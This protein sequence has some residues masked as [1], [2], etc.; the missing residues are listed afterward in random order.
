[1][2]QSSQQVPR[3]QDPRFRGY[4]RL[5]GGTGHASIGRTF[6]AAYRDMNFFHN[7]S[8]W[9]EDRR[10]YKADPNWTEERRQLHLQMGGLHGMVEKYPRLASAKSLSEYRMV[11]QRASQDLA[12]RAILHRLGFF[13]SLMYYLPVGMTSPENW[14]PLSRAFRFGMVGKRAG[15]FKVVASKAHNLA[16]EAERRALAA[17]HRTNP[18]LVHAAHLADDMT[19]GEAQ[20]LLARAALAQTTVAQAGAATGLEG[21]IAASVSEMLLQKVQ[22][23]RTQEET[24]MS[25][26][27]GGVFGA[28]LGS[29]FYVIGKSYRKV[30]TDLLGAETHSDRARIASHEAQGATTAALDD[31]SLGG[32]KHKETGD[33]LP[34]GEDPPPGT[35]ADFI[36]VEATPEDVPGFVAARVEE[37][38]VARAEAREA[39]A[40]EDGEAREQGQLEFEQ[41]TIETEATVQDL[42]LATEAEL[43]AAHRFAER[44]GALSED[45]NSVHSKI[46]R[47]VGIGDKNTFWG[48]LIGRWLLWSPNTRMGLEETDYGRQLYQLFSGGAL[49]MQRGSRAG[50]ATRPSIDITATFMELMLLRDIGT[51]AKMA[52]EIEASS[53]VSEIDLRSLAH[54]YALRALDDTGAWKGLDL[55]AEYPVAGLLGEGEGHV[56]GIIRNIEDPTMKQ[57]AIDGVERVI[58]E[59]YHPFIEKS[60]RLLQAMGLLDYDTARNPAMAAMYV[61]RMYDSTAIRRN[62]DA[63][64]AAVKEGLQEFREADDPTLRRRIEHQEAVVARE[65]NAADVE[66]LAE[67]KGDLEALRGDIDDAR[68]HAVV[69]NIINDPINSDLSGSRMHAQNALHKRVL[70]LKDEFVEPFLVKD[71]GLVMQTITKRHI[72]KV[73]IYRYLASPQQ[74]ELMVRTLEMRERVELGIA[75]L[76]DASDKIRDDL[77]E[78]EIKQF[79]GMVNDLLQEINLLRMHNGLRLLSVF[80]NDVAGLPVEGNGQVFDLVGH[81]ERIAELLQEGRDTSDTRHGVALRLKGL[82]EELITLSREAENAA[83]PVEMSAGPMDLAELEQHKAGLRRRMLA[84]LVERHETDPEVQGGLGDVAAGTAELHREGTDGARAAKDEAFLSDLEG[85]VRDRVQAG[86]DEIAG[87]PRVR[88][89][90]NRGGGVSRQ[91]ANM[92]VGRWLVYLAENIHDKEGL[93]SEGWATREMVDFVEGRFLRM[94]ED[95]RKNVPG[96]KGRM[97]IAV[98]PDDVKILIEAFRGADFSTAVHEVGH[99]LRMRTL[100]RAKIR[101]D[102]AGGITED[103]LEGLELWANDGRALSDLVDGERVWTTAMEEKFAKAFEQYIAEG[104]FAEGV[105]RAVKRVFE[106]LKRA[107]RAVYGVIS[108]RGGHWEEPL[109]PAVKKV[110]DK[111]LLSDDD[112]AAYAIREINHKLTATQKRQIKDSFG[113]SDEGADAIYAIYDALNLDKRELVFRAPGE[114][115]PEGFRESGG[116]QQGRQTFEGFLADN[117]VGMDDW[118]REATNHPEWKARYGKEIIEGRIRT[119]GF[120]VESSAGVLFRDGLAETAR[121]HRFGKAVEVKDEAFYLDPAVRVYLARDATAGLVITPE[122]DLISVHKLP[123]SAADIDEI[124]AQASPFAETLDAFDI[125]GHLPTLYARHGWRPVSRAEFNPE[126]RPEGWDMRPIDEGGLGKPDIVLMVY[127]P[128]DVLRLPNAASFNAVRGEVPFFPMAKYDDAVALHKEAQGVLRRDAPGRSAEELE[129]K[130]KQFFQQSGRESFVPDMETNAAYL[131]DELADG[132]T[133]LLDAGYDETRFNYLNDDGVEVTLKNDGEMIY[134]NGEQFTGDI[135]I[136]LILST[137]ARGQGAASKELDRILA[138]ADARDMSVSLVV[139]AQNVRRQGQA[140]GLNDAQLKAWYQRKGFVFPHDDPE[141]TGAGYRPRKADADSVIE[142]TRQA[143]EVELPAAMKQ[144]ADD[145]FKR[146][147]SEP[148]EMFG[149]FERGELEP[150]FHAAEPDLY[151]FEGYSPNAKEKL[152]Y[153]GRGRMTRAEWD[154]LVKDSVQSGRP[155]RVDNAVVD[156]DYDTG[157]YTASLTDPPTELRQTSEPLIAFRAS[158]G[159][160]ASARQVHSPDVIEKIWGDP[161]PGV[162]GRDT[163]EDTPI[164]GRWVRVD[165]DG[166]V[167]PNLEGTPENF[168][169]PL[170]LAELQ[171]RGY[172]G[173][174]RHYSTEW[175]ENV[176]ERH[177]AG[178]YDVPYDLL[179]L[180]ERVRE[181]VADERYEA[182]QG[183]P[184]SSDLARVGMDLEATKIFGPAERV[185]LYLDSINHGRV[186]QHFGMLDQAPRI[187]ADAIK[188]AT[189]KAEAILLSRIEAVVARQKETLPGPDADAVAKTIAR[190]IES[191][192]ISRQVDMSGGILSHRKRSARP[193]ITK[194]NQ[195]RPDFDESPVNEIATKSQKFIYPD[196]YADERPGGIFGDE[197]IDRTVERIIGTITKSNKEGSEAW[198]GAAMPLIARVGPLYKF[199][200]ETA[201]APDG[202]ESLLHAM[203][204]EAVAEY[205]KLPKRSGPL[206]LALTAEFSGSD[207]H[208][209]STELKKL[210]AMKQDEVKEKGGVFKSEAAEIA[211]RQKRLDAAES[212]G[213]T[214][215]WYNLTVIQAMQGAGGID[216]A[217][218]L[219]RAIMDLVVESHA[220]GAGLEAR[221]KSFE[222]NIRLSK[223][224]QARRLEYRKKHPSGGGFDSK[225]WREW[226]AAFNKEKW[227]PEFGE[228]SRAEAHGFGHVATDPHKSKPN[229]PDLHSFPFEG[230]MVDLETI[231]TMLPRLVEEYARY[232][233]EMHAMLRVMYPTGLVPV[234]RKRNYLG[235]IRAAEE[236][237]RV[238]SHPDLRPSTLQTMGDRYSLSTSLANPE[239]WA[240]IHRDDPSTVAGK[241]VDADK[242]AESDQYRA[243]DWV[244]EVV[245]VE[246]IVFL[247]QGYEAEAIVRTEALLYNKHRTVDDLYQSSERIAEIMAEI[248]DLQDGTRMSPTE[249]V[250]R[251][252]KRLGWQTPLGEAMIGG[253][254][255]VTPKQLES[256]MLVLQAN[257]KRMMMH[258]LATDAA[259]FWY[260]DSAAGI[261][262]AFQ[263]DTFQ[264]AMFIE[265]LA[266]TSANTNPKQNLNNALDTMAKILNLRDLTGGVKDLSPSHAYPSTIKPKLEKIVV[267][268]AA[269]GRAVTLGDKDWS[270]RLSSGMRNS[271][272]TASFSRTI[273]RAMQFDIFDVERAGNW[274]EELHDVVA[275]VWMFRHFMFGESGAY[276]DPRSFN[277]RMR[278]FNRHYDRV[279]KD[280][281]TEENRARRKAEK[282]SKPHRLSSSSR[283][284]ASGTDYKFMVDMVEMLTDELNEEAFKGVTDWKPWQVQATLWTVH[285]FIEAG[286]SDPMV[287]R[288]LMNN[289]YPT[290]SNYSHLPGKTAAHL[291]GY[292]GLPHNHQMRVAQWHR[293]ALSDT[294]E[295]S[296][297]IAADTAPEHA[298]LDAALGAV[299]GE[300]HARATEQVRRVVTE[301]VEEVVRVDSAVTPRGKKAAST[302]IVELR[303]LDDDRLRVAGVRMG[304]AG[305]YNNVQTFRVRPSGKQALHFVD[306]DDSFTATQITNLLRRHSIKRFQITKASDTATGYRVV[307]LD[308]TYGRGAQL[309]SPILMKLRGFSDAGKIKTHKEVRGT[310][311]QVGASDKASKGEVERAYADTLR[312]VDERATRGD[313][314]RAAGI[315]VG[316]ASARGV[317]GTAKSGHDAPGQDAV[318]LALGLPGTTATTGAV[319]GTTRL[320]LP[321]QVISTEVREATEAWIRETNLG[322][323]GK[324]ML[325]VVIGKLAGVLNDG[326]HTVNAG[327]QWAAATAALRKLDEISWCRILEPG[328]THKSLHN[329]YSVILPDGVLWD[330]ASVQSLRAHLDGL[331]PIAKRL[332]FEQQSPESLGLYITTEE[333]GLNWFP[334]AKIGSKAKPTPIMPDLLSQLSD[335]RSRVE[336]ALG[337]WNEGRPDS[338]VVDYEGLTYIGNKLENDWSVYPNGEGYLDAPWKGPGGKAVKARV[339]GVVRKL[340]P[341]MDLAD[342]FAAARFDLRVNPGLLTAY[343]DPAHHASIESG[344]GT[345]TF[346]RGGADPSARG[347]EPEH[348]QQGENRR[349]SEDLERLRLGSLFD[350]GEISGNREKIEAALEKIRGGRARVEAAIRAAGGDENPDEILNGLLAEAMRRAEQTGEAPEIPG[351]PRLTAGLEDLIAARGRGDDLGAARG[352][353]DAADPAGAP[354]RGEMAGANSGH[355][356]ARHAASRAESEFNTARDELSA[357]NNDLGVPTD[358]SSRGRPASGYDPQPYSY[359]DQNQPVGEQVEAAYGRVSAATDRVRSETAGDALSLEPHLAMIRRGYEEKLAAARAAGDD[360]EVKRLGRQFETTARDLQAMKDRVLNTHGINTD[361]VGYGMR[362]SKAA[363]DFNYIRFMG[364]VTLSSLPDLAMGISVAGLRPYLTAWAKML[365]AEIL[366]DEVAR[367]DIA[368][369]IYASETV[370]GEERVRKLYFLDDNPMQIEQTRAEKGLEW[371]AR[372]FSKWSG[373]QYWNAVN[374]AVAATALQSRVI[375]ISRK[376]RAGTVSDLEL[377]MIGQFGID[378]AMATRIARVHEAV[379]ET[380]RDLFGG[381]FYHSRV[382]LWDGPI[383]GL[384]HDEVAFLREQYYAAIMQ[385]TN[386]TIVTPNAG[387]LP[388]IATSTGIGKLLFQFKSFSFAATNSVLISGLQRGLEYGDISQVMLLVGL[389][390]LGGFVYAGKEWLGGRDP[391]RFDNDLSKF[392]VEGMDRGGGL[393]ILSEAN[394]IFEKTFGL[395]LSQFADSGPLSRYSS[396]NKMDALMGPT[397][398]TAKDFLTLAGSVPKMFTDDKVSGY[399]VDAARR[400]F[401]FQNLI[402]VRLAM[403]VGP[404]IIQGG[405]DFF[406]NFKPIHRRI[407]GVAGFGEE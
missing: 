176:Q 209:K 396:R 328:A 351:Y 193:V 62:Y 94:T 231:R 165:Q 235:N 395:G 53:G 97:V 117:K 156:F 118:L 115:L 159:V 188:P 350:E 262:D 382:D 349:L 362:L 385:A 32:W 243:S 376:V 86:F 347:R 273:Q 175:R 325:D 48:R 92:G 50:T 42:T 36:R 295:V 154:A 127:D 147:H 281:H 24:W 58:R 238:P 29:G 19:H 52:R 251:T 113:L 143:T 184:S 76:K 388:L 339:Q 224:Y 201:T 381:E 106:S 210:L 216:E 300:D 232:R 167:Y 244:T 68:L 359:I 319:T 236:S 172:K 6:A 253:A 85:G 397:F 78:A 44:M 375:E 342:E 208:G 38:E 177:E 246:D 13:E 185:S 260:E 363:R 46:A 205:G 149:L 20:E 100:T 372:K 80:K 191:Y 63:F 148:D 298:T 383:A 207:V 129:V 352:A 403:D 377:E 150:G 140:V 171:K 203:V 102:E 321:G 263:G 272:K 196:R 370:L 192:M 343:R 391:F 198:M 293:N 180:T 227:Q 265:I 7:L 33:Y 387:D 286:E 215:P 83:Y 18:T 406:A 345:N 2:P 4:G 73:A 369:L 254:N 136:D 15:D 247:G 146:T 9:E 96:A 153:H 240:S 204:R 291:L 296:Y 26:V 181:G 239:Y 178:E 27:G 22:P 98:G 249:A 353:L 145:S 258:P 335:V 266:I 277:V 366:N 284:L 217:G 199:L 213:L 303:T 344:R 173:G 67:L 187:E 261:L 222:A 360:K 256:M 404:S 47:L 248:K 283:S 105:S 112:I 189:R 190:M 152:P 312:G 163:L 326:V 99:A 41:S 274:Q 378:E 405:D 259:R 202:E 211:A 64:I 43:F 21:M 346:S 30:L 402:Q 380:G 356:A 34:V 11:A 72:P 158:Q 157:N 389:S 59:V 304:L 197:G 54:S 373:I 322:Q 179:P 87:S 234:I 241:R 25:I 195:I 137:G 354:A 278:R 367:A 337:K 355:R 107:M 124:L 122:R 162:V 93:V 305:G 155:L 379:G 88:T 221:I 368:K 392:I 219:G 299:G 79:F 28:V 255:P 14:V 332:R 315:P 309:R 302:Q 130:A 371:S 313:E 225:Q 242:L 35:E 37:A 233:T 269:D 341:R 271:F 109:N 116:L 200:R 364:G 220:G 374:K 70:L 66:L 398:G 237:F 320:F 144:V 314:A 311:E 114:S 17:A 164:R 401:A 407:A 23:L 55:E 276:D 316:Y 45:T 84:D 331:G 186:M 399:E 77:S 161:E 135:E 128:G 65:P 69:R 323:G 275:D 90:D 5:P 329:G 214:N 336:Q 134:I 95:L 166:K 168:G 288:D 3:H 334:D 56:Y 327:N 108:G 348:F 330:A 229:K 270:I 357:I 310:V 89:N 384:R 103:E 131:A 132:K 394:A 324:E 301:E 111:V 252:M 75:N 125:N 8:R 151:F 206:L 81:T 120:R 386:R 245:A 282:S 338:G 307:I 121:T 194:E 61:T 169:T 264:A 361:A 218:L 123:G 139:S 285:R 182:G 212:E 230:R 49:T 133:R 390:S 104:T 82:G 297:L 57:A 365:K 101:R 183:R 110:L 333:G 71:V 126:F 289:D 250:A 40:R 294:E 292:D 290:R 160:P 306:F 268:Y 308:D 318:L 174:I 16:S 228:H 74:L 138:A 39:A 226:E 287:Y 12:D 340:L 91:V 267:G 51:L 279:A 170:S 223:E 31:I 1:M 142:K 317:G 280:G 10:S 60:S 400:M 358:A 257:S 119:G 141:G 393:G